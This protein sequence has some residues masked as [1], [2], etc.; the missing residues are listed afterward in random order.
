MSQD[1]NMSN[2]FILVDPNTDLSQFIYYDSIAQMELTLCTFSSICC[3]LNISIL[4]SPKL[5]D[6]LYKYIMLIACTD[7]LYFLLIIINNVLDVQCQPVPYLCR[8]FAQFI[9]FLNDQF[10]INYLT[11]CLAVFSILSEIFLTTQ[12]LFLIKNYK[13][14]RSLTWK[15]VAPVIGLIS[16][17]YYSPYWFSYGM[18]TTGLVYSYK[19]ENYTEWTLD[20]T[21]FGK[22]Q[23][24]FWLLSSLSIVRTLL[25][26]IVLS[27]LN[28]ASI[29]V[30]RAY[31]KKKSIMKIYSSKKEAYFFHL[32]MRD[33]F[34]F[35]LRQSN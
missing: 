16:L 27:S 31:I 1:S 29:I 9:S 25:V 26:M 15:H 33:I 7:L 4:A 35:E 13:Y 8:S 11:S 20:K 3:I 23:A 14:L 12:R 5:K 19:G 17:I 18:T 32:F 34:F 28:V 22:T 2:S 6:P 30:F 10:S 24:S 21:E